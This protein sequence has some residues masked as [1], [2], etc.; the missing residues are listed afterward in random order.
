MVNRPDPAEDL[1]RLSH[2]TYRR[3]HEAIRKGEI[4]PGT[5][6]VER[7]IAEKLGVSRMPVRAAI[8][9]LIENGFAT[10]EPHRVA[11]VHPFSLKELDEVYSVRVAL[12]RLVVE[13]ALAHWTPQ[14]YD[15][16]QHIVDAMS[17]PPSDPN[18][19]MKQN[20]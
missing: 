19:N 10:K 1:P 5:R 12:E 3:I 15:K 7:D 18:L 4:T 20:I 16:L 17:Q 11:Y 2:E 9:K 8:E 14:A 6:L 13:Y